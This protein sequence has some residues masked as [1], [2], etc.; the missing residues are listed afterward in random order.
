[1]SLAGFE[2]GELSGVGGSGVDHYAIFLDFDG[3]M[4]RIR[5]LCSEGTSVSSLQ[6][7]WAALDGEERGRLPAVARRVGR[8]GGFVV[9]R[10]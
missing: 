6:K 7:I 4:A 8:S 10:R 3:M 5:R 1:M 2:H 9:V